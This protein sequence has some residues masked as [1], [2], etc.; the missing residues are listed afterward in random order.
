MDID[1]PTFLGKLQKGI[2]EDYNVDKLKIIYEEGVFKLRFRYEIDKEHVDGLKGDF[3]QDFGLEIFKL[4]DETFEEWSR[5]TSVYGDYCICDSC[6]TAK[7]E[8][9]KEEDE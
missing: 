5:G 3:Y 1:I 9:K 7:H 4:G 6:Q 2:E 8:V